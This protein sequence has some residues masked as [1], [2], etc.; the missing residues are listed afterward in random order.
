MVLSVN[1]KQND[2]NTELMFVSRRNSFHNTPE[3]VFLQDNEL[4]LTT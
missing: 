2:D 1:L 4:S 3:N